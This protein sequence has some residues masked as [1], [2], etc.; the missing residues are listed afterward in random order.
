MLL[1][2][3]VDDF[4]FARGES[5]EGAYGPLF[6]SFDGVGLQGEGE[7]RN[8]L[9]L[10]VLL[11]TFRA[12]EKYVPRRTAKKDRCLLGSG[13]IICSS[14]LKTGGF[15]KHACEITGPSPP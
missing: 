3:T 15:T 1:R 14:R 2:T 11:H 12:N 5:K 8:P 9:P 13:L 6:V 7:I 4:P 10:G